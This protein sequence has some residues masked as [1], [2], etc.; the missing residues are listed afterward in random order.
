MGKLKLREMFFPQLSCCVVEVGI[1]QL[2][3][4]SKPYTHLLTSTTTPP[5]YFCYQMLVLCLQMHVL[6]NCFLGTVLAHSNA[7]QGRGGV[8]IAE[9]SL[10]GKKWN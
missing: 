1:H 8:S 7:C 4:D 3:T 6:F 5:P 10:E 9:G 2:E